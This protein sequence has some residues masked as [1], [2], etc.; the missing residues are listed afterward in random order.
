MEAYYGK[1]YA[2]TYFSTKFKMD[3]EKYSYDTSDANIGLNKIYA[4]V[5]S[6][7]ASASEATLVG[8]MPYMDVE[9]IGNRT[10]GKHC[11]GVMF[12]A[13]EY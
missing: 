10:G 11:S 6:G 2:N 1:D 12:E 9:V 8:L 13:K 5:T 3:S 7:T 4:L